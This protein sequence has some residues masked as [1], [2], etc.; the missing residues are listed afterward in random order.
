MTQLLPSSIEE[1][2]I[3]LIL[4]GID[5]IEAVKQ[6]IHAENALIEEMIER[7]TAR[8]IKATEQI[9]RNV[10]ALSNLFN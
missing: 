4:K 9:K 8:S 10:F 5:P 1:R 6:A 3:E 2:A 7:R